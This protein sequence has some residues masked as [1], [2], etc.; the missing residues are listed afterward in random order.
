L[1]S[2]LSVWI[3]GN[4]PHI[5]LIDWNKFPPITILSIKSGKPLLD[6]PSIAEIYQSHGKFKI[7]SLKYGLLNAASPGTERPGEL[8]SATFEGMFHYDDLG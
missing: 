4:F 1:R 2:V 6:F 7:P 8:K 3:G 5:A